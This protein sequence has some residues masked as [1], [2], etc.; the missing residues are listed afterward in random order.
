MTFAL[1]CEPIN[2][3]RRDRRRGGKCNETEREEEKCVYAG[4]VWRDSNW[5]VSKLIMNINIQLN[6][7]IEWDS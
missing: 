3:C 1:S 7:R 2:T 4:A 6:E 5:T